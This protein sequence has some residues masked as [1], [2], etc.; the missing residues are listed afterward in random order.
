MNYQHLD[1]KEI[2]STVSTLRKRITER[3]P[4]SGLSKVCSELQQIAE[5]AITTSQR[6]QAPMI[7]FRVLIWCGFVL[8]LVLI[9][10]AIY[11]L[12]QAAK[13]G[14]S[15]LA[16]VD[17]EANVLVL[18]GGATVFLWT[19]EIRYKRDR[20]L[21]A[22]HELRSIAHIIDMHQLTKDPEKLFTKKI[23]LTSSSPAM[24]MTPF[25]LRRYLDYCSEMLS[26]TGKIAAVYVQTFDD[27]VTVASASDVETL[28]TGLS[29]KIW[30][31][32][33]IVN[34]LRDDETTPNGIHTP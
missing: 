4:D 21:K 16:S 22:I 13:A 28:T 8:F 3:F 31:K 25:E 34:P 6:I 10:G 15:L 2:V 29:R 20:A 19:L 30:Q 11:F 27:P 5:N 24:N 14:E 33:L 32:I 17:A 7:W 12:I 9:F 18:L 23:H 1:P 26:L